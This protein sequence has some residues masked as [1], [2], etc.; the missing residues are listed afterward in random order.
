MAV[1]AAVSAELLP[2]Y[3][4]YNTPQSAPAVTN[5]AEL[6]Y[7]TDREEFLAICEGVT[8][9]FD[10][11]SA[12]GFT[13]IP[14]PLDQYS[15]NDAYSPGSILPGIV[16]STPGGILNAELVVVGPGVFGAISYSVHSNIFSDTLN[17]SFPDQEIHGN[18][19]CVGMDLGSLFS[20]STLDLSIHGAED[21]S[22]G[23]TTALANTTTSAFWGVV[24][25][26]GV[27]T[28]IHLAS[29]TF[30]TDTCCTEG[31]DNV[32]FGTTAE[33]AKLLSCAGGSFEPP[34]DGP[35]VINNSSMRVIPV[36]MTLV[37]EDGIIFG[38]YDFEQ[39]PVIYIDPVAGGTSE[40]VYLSDEDM[41]EASA[42]SDDDVFRYDPVTYLWMYN[43]RPTE[44]AG[45]FRVTAVSMDESYIIDAD[46]CSS[47]Y[48]REE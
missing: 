17:L 20:A 3:S 5:T 30:P 42:A 33:T 48:T 29:A 31:V 10:I 21:V 32:T 15:D 8:E 28:R 9:T 2:D 13:A 11:T 45:Q 22:L 18:V 36:G 12:S 16:V 14:K 23:E 4:A 41:L 1:P 34:F 27:I 6:K 38:A 37:D 40:A 24:S 44:D 26:I 35:I 25:T 39:P 19:T 47:T 7:F 43:L 46:T